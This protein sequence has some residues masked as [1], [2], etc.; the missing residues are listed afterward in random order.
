MSDLYR[1]LIRQNLRKGKNGEEFW[2]R[3]NS[4]DN[5]MPIES[6]LQLQVQGL[7]K[8][9]QNAN[10]N[11]VNNFLKK[12]QTM[13][14]QENAQMESLIAN[15]AYA[16]IIELLNA[17]LMKSEQNPYNIVKARGG[18]TDKNSSEMQ[19]EISK[20]ISE[21]EKQ[22]ASINVSEGV[23]HDIV[24][25]LQNRLN[26]FQWGPTPQSY[27]MEKADLVEALMADRI[28]QNPNLRAIVTGSWTNQGKQLI[29]DMLA[30]TTGQQY[31][32][33]NGDLAKMK[34]TITVDGKSSEHIASSAGNL[35][36]QLDNINGTNY[37]VSL[38][39]ELYKALQA[40]AIIS[41]QAKSGVGDQAILNK[42]KR[43]SISLAE[44]NFDP[45]LLWELYQVDMQDQTEYFKP[46]NE[47]S[48]ETL[49]ALANLAL[50]K[51]IG[52]TALVS[53][54]L[55]L[56]KDGFETAS[57]WMEK[58]NRYLEFNPA[59]RRVNSAF[60]SES[61]PYFFTE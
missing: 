32:V 8:I 46:Y 26:S 55:Y 6:F 50:S 33:F 18:N 11:E 5:V 59:V 29:E 34:F 25:A 61:R 10:Y 17:G 30:F 44:I 39:D 47:Q 27:I 4:L 24:Q 2:G 21:L 49:K 37:S 9:E 14:D 54:K 41:G 12:A 15:E 52:K 28:N 16:R 48:S 22:L 19:G 53:N 56:T 38:S 20:T 1:G 31:T 36:D 40:A 42:N 7:K 35:L 13:V 23:S 60:M 51:N 3:F 43:N 58:H 45:Q 57:Q